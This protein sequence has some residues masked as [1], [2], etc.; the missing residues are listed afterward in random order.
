MHAAATLSLFALA[1]CAT[2]NARPFLPSRDF[3]IAKDGSP[4]TL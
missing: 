2:M 3:G 1:A 4:T